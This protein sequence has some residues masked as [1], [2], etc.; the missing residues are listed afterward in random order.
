MTCFKYSPSKLKF[1][2]FAVAF[3]IGFI[4][5]YF[6][7]YAVDFDGMANIDIAEEL[8]NGNPKSVF[9]SYW[10][11]LYP[12]I[13]GSFFYLFKHSPCWESIFV[14]FINFFIFL[15]SF[16]SFT[17]FLN[18][19][20]KCQKQKQ[21][22]KE[23]LKLGLNT[24]PEWALITLG[25][26][27]FIWTSVSLITISRIMSDLSAAAIFYFISGLLLK[28]RLGNTN[29]FLFILLGFAFS[30]FY[31]AKLSF[32]SLV[33][34]FLFLCFFMGVNLRLMLPRVLLSLIVFLVLISPFVFLLSREKGYFTFGDATKLNY[35]E[36]VT[37]EITICPTSMNYIP[38]L[39]NLTHP[40]KKIYA[41]PAVYEY[42]TPFKVTYSPYYDPSFWWHGLKTKFDLMGELRAIKKNLP[43][44]MDLISYMQIVLVGLFML[45]FIS[46]RGILCL[47]DIFE[48]WVLLV[49]TVVP[50]LMCSLIHAE[51]RYFGAFVPVLILALLSALKFNNYKAF[52]KAILCLV[53]MVIVFFLSTSI[54][55]LDILSNIKNNDAYKDWLVSLEL[56]K[57]GIKKGDKAAVIPGECD[58]YWARLAKVNIIAE[59][60]LEDYEM[61]WGSSS[62]IKSEILEAF[63]RV[64]VKVVLAENPP[65]KY[66]TQEGWINIK[67]TSFYYY[68]L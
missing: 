35:I 57:I 33:F 15:I 53:S 18:E 65:V 46:S 6:S 23:V 41:S 67:D 59:V 38:Q 16:F 43:I 48:E 42:S 27:V 49:S 52:K 14:H 25:Y 47:K 61:F 32:L 68:V 63:K 31:L 34:L 58:V 2:F 54:V 3:V 66:I 21:K 60:S 19:L 8:F 9:I 50:I 22:E 40:V 24:L 37:N 36:E 10:S 29:W 20:V 28:I 1:F 39:S 62:L 30:C 45:F 12:I 55:S 44:Y 51:F 64:G 17:F 56:K 11:P 4:N 7:R 13:L 5:T 26:S